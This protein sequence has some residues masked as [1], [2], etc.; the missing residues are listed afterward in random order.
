MLTE[1]RHCRTFGYFAPMAHPARHHLDGA[2]RAASGDVARLPVMFQIAHRRQPTAAGAR[3]G[4]QDQ[5][6]LAVDSGKNRGDQRL[7]LGHPG[8]AGDV[9]GEAFILCQ[10]GPAKH[11]VTQGRPSAQRKAP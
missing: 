9:G 8:N 5:G 2:G 1:G 3:T 6:S 7:D 4:Q 10:G 11:A